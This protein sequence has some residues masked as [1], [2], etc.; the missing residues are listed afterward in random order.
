[1]LPPILRR[2]RSATL[3][4]GL[5]GLTGS[6]GLAVPALASSTAPAAATAASQAPVLT[7]IHASH[8]RGYD[9]LIFQFTGSLPAHRSAHYVSAA[10]P[11]RS[12]GP[13]PAAG[14]ARLLIS[15]S[16]TRG[17]GRPTVADVQPT[18]RTYALP[19]LIQL[20]KVPGRTG[21]ADFSAGLAR[22]EPFRVFARAH[23]SRVIIDVRTPYRTVRVHDYFLSSRQIAAG[24]PPYA[25]AVSRR[26][27]TSSRP[28]RALQ[29]LFAG[30]TPA[31]HARGLRFVASGATGFTRLTIH[32]GVARL[33]LTGA[34]RS[35]GAAVTVAS[36]IVPTLRQFSWVRW[37]KIYDAAGETERPA[38]DTSSLP[39]CLLPPHPLAVFP[40]ILV[41]VVTIA[42]ALG[43]LLGLF[44]TM[45]GV[46]SG[47]IRRPNVITPAAYQQERVAAQPVTTGQFEPDSAWPAYPFRQI[48]ADLGRIISATGAR[49]QKFWN[50]PFGPVIWVLLT[51]ISAVMVAFLAA[52]AVTAALLLA[53]LALVM[54]CGA[55]L[56]AVAFAAVL[57]L[58][59]GT[60]AAWHA[61]IRTE[62]SCPRCYHRTARPAYRC[63]ACSALHRELRP[64]RMGLLA[65][66]CACGKLLPA[67]VQRATWRLDA[68]CQRCQEPLTRGSAVLRDVRIP[69]FGDVSAGKTRF[70]YAGL[71]SLIQTARAADIDFG[72]PDQDAER[73]ANLALDLIRSGR[74]TVKTAFALPT[75]LTGRLGSGISGALVHLFDAAGEYFRD[76]QWHDSLGFL[77]GG[78]GL[79]YVLDPFSIGSVR[80]QLA[81]HDSDAL[82][83]ENA[84]A[85]D[86]EAAYGRVVSRLRDSGV[87]AREQ[88]LALVVS[89]ADRLAL[90]GLDLPDES[91]AVA[92]WLRRM[93]VH[94]LVLSTRRDFAEVRYFA[95]ASM[96]GAAVGTH[97]P[98]APLR[99]ILRSCGV[100]LPDR[101]PA[102]PGPDPRGTGDPADREPAGHDRPAD[103]A[104]EATVPHEPA[105][106]P[107]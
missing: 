101:P 50:W 95:V 59:R 98:G 3:A 75:A 88:R 14:S 69:I 84:A 49:Y 56:G 76:P 26:V 42:T 80:D 36:E 30:P 13:V 65:R 51:P 99:W 35:D 71:N 32:R 52:A 82:Q 28:F 1:V 34:C 20:V 21:T 27:I 78:Q 55:A 96:A 100:R 6:A 39:D 87:P 103:A 25:R 58:L 94:N 22:K 54:W 43:I 61:V 64:G 23:P 93:G 10:A 8:H 72:F 7:A 41:I 37:V 12:G 63:P 66:R 53:L 90:A 86:P 18:R 85:G 62:A 9:Q 81:Q 48:R 97:D 57:I 102:A 92:D 2:L 74:D 83:L 89:K 4:L 31:E 46:V 60:D 67:M 73:D 24:Q 106:A 44:L 17:P 11:S 45:T 19:G 107:S 29:R 105:E 15:F 5:A 91:E 33:R 38:G 77:D 16:G 40:R 70:L 47:L 104:P 79:V 68:V